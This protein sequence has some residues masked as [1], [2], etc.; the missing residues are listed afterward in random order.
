MNVF[1]L[2]FKNLFSR[3]MRSVLT[4]TMLTMG[5]ALASL[6]ILVG[7]ALDDSF[8]K[9]IRGIDMVVG[10][11]GSPLQLILSAVYQIDNPTG[12]INLE[13]VRKL[14][15]NPQIKESIELSFGDSYK[16]RRI[17]GTSHEYVELYDGSVSDGALWQKPFE[18]V[19]GAQV[20]QEFNLK[21][22][23][24]FVSAHGVDGMGHAHEEHP[25][26]VVGVLNS[27]GSV[28]DKLI[29]TAPESIWKVHGD[30]NQ[31]S[32]ATQEITAMLVKF[33]NKMGIMTLPR[34]VNQQTSMQAALPAIEVNR[35]FELF[36]VAI[37]TLQIVAFVIM[38][39]GAISVLVSMINALKD[40]AYEMALMRSMGASRGQIFGM[41][42]IEAVMMGVIG[43]A[44]GIV[45]SHIGVAFLNT[46]SN[47]QFGI[48]VALWRLDPLEWYLIA[49]TIVLCIFAALLP[50]FT[51]IR[52]DVSKILSR[53]EN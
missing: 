27:S 6:L 10:A 7:N 5:V 32:L 37:S 15:K 36:G 29:L 23:D 13:E 19:V 9:N 43:T 24:Q 45:L 44:L 33:R 35:L 4:V 20:A 2:S 8:K 50:A 26:T 12:N 49:A 1:K 21:K 25:F 53:Y 3:P 22:G 46:Y 14:A 17:V 40:R 31:D 52:L 47:E 39:L 16:G 30:H 18:A 42:L 28:L 48:S 38:L 41:I 51:T 11:K 34:I